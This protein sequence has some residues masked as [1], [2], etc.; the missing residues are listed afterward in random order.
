M[1][2]VSG[3]SWECRKTTY[4]LHEWDKGQWLSRHRRLVEEHNREVDML[5]DEHRRCRQTSGADL[6][7]D[8][9]TCPKSKET[10]HIGVK[11]NISV[12]RRPLD[13]QPALD[14]PTHLL[15]LFRRLEQVAMR[16]PLPQ[17]VLL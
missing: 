16:V 8:V 14:V 7:S 1:T 5:Q 15:P 17:L 9:A 11:Q 10:Y 6:S 2:A 13:R 3:A 4:T 12:H